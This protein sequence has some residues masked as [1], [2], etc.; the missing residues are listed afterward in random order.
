MFFEFFKDLH[1]VDCIYISN[2][3]I[4]NFV[5]LLAAEPNLT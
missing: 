3:F 5:W 4:L 2:Y 1:V